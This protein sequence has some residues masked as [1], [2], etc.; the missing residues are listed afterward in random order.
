MAVTPETARKLRAHGHAL[1]VQTQAGLS[2]S[3]TDEAYQ[4]AGAEITDAMGAFDC[5]LVLKVRNVFDN[6]AAMMKP[7][8]TLVGMLNPFDPNGLQH[9]AAAGVTS[10]ALEAARVVVLGVGV[11]GL[12][13]I[14]IAIATAKRL[15]LPFTL[16][17]SLNK[18]V[19]AV[20]RCACM[21]KTR[22]NER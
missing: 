17:K 12:Q 4:A 10:F 9:L 5:D 1:R 18:F 13:A 19:R 22:S 20:Y 11:E 3:G 21:H 8:S 7:G 14:A 15:V 6:E 16:E 2:A